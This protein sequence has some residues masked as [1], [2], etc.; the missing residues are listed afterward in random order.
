MEKEESQRKNPNRHNTEEP[1]KARDGQE[2]G[3]QRCPTVE[4]VPQKPKKKKKRKD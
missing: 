4:M 3:P 2:E 1:G